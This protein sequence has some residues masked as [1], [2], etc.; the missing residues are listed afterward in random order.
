MT[1]TS[2]SSVADLVSAVPEVRL[3][4]QH[5]S[6]RPVPYNM[7]DVSFLIGSVPGCD[8]RVPGTNLPPV[9]CLLQRRPGNVVLRKLAPA[10]PILVNGA[11][12]ANAALKHGDRLTLGVVDVVVQIAAGTPEAGPAQTSMHIETARRQLQQQLQVFRE[13]VLQF[14][15]QKISWEQ[16]RQQLEQQLPPRTTKTAGGKDDV[17]A[18]SETALTKKAEELEQFRQ[19]LAAREA[20]LD[21]QRQELAAMR[22]EL[23]NIRKELYDKYQERRDKLAGIQEAVNKAARKVQERKQQV[24]G[25]LLQMNLRQQEAGRRERDLDDRAAEVSLQQQRLEEE[26]RLLGERHRESQQ[27]LTQRLADCQRHE[28]KLTDERRQLEQDQAQYQEDLVRLHRLQGTLE[29][30]DKKLQERA[31]ALDSRGNDLQAQEQKLEEQA[32]QLDEWHSR[33]CALAEQLDR[34]KQKQQDEAQGLAQKTTA[35][36]GQQAMLTNLRGRLEQMRD[37]LRK[38]EQQ[39]TEECAQQQEREK[40]LQAQHTELQQLRTT[41]ETEKAALEQERLQLTERGKTLENAVSQLRQAQTKLAEAE[42][43]LQQDAQ[44]LE[45][46]ITQEA[47]RVK[48]VETKEVQLDELQQRLEADRQALLERMQLLSQ[49]EQ[50]RE[51]LQEQ[52][53]RRSEELS[54]RQKALDEQTRQYQADLQTLRQQQQE[55]EQQQQQMTARVQGHIQEIEV[56]AEEMARQKEELTQREVQLESSREKLQTQGRSIAEKLKQLQTERA[57]LTQLA[58]ETTAATQQARSEY[59]AAR[60]EALDLQ[61][62]L[63][64]LELRAGTAFERLS[65][66]RE[67]LREYIGEVHTYANQCQEHL[68]GLRSGIQSEGERLHTREQA[69]RKQQ[70]EQRLALAGFRQQLIDWQGQMAEIKRLLAENEGRLELRQAEV[71]QKARLVTEESSRLAQQAVELEAEKRAVAHR[72]E[73]IDQHLE[74]MQQWYRHKLRELSGVADAV[75]IGSAGAAATSVAGEAVPGRD[76]LSL[77]GAVDP[78]DR[79]L[80][81]TLQTLGLIDT[82]VLTALL[83]EARRQRRSLRQVLLASG[84]VTLYQM[85]LIEAG[86]LDGLM[87][88]P[89]R[90]VDRLYAT[91]HEAVYRV[92]DPQRGQEAVLRHLSEAEMEDAV[93]PDEFRQRFTQAM[94][95]HPNIQATLTVLDLA[96]RPAALQEWLTGLVSLDWPQLAAVPGVWF[97]LVN[98]A[99]LALHTGHQAGL[100]HGHLRPNDFLLTSDGVVKLCGLSDPPWLVL[101]PVEEIQDSSAG[102]MAV[103]GRIVSRWAEHGEGRRGKAFPAGLKQI[104]ERLS[105]AS[106][107][108]GYPETGTLLQALDAV[109]AEVPANPEAWDRL[110]RHV[111][112]HAIG[113]P[114]LR[115]SA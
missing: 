21:R 40:D 53:R 91:A 31:A 3:E 20:D 41:L 83:I 90:V 56:R 44:A 37:E 14:E 8:L 113:G 63:P 6:A 26:R 95:T 96:G 27:Q 34:Q 4:V 80:G 54:A 30:Q 74:D 48:T 99:A 58:Q 84:T 98:Q 93:H 62:K 77:T 1:Q 33:L 66:A 69:L 112:E 81:T 89:V 79:E 28:Q 114:V 85:A 68:D 2:S 108:D 35:L 9:L 87:L 73:T 17:S 55:L 46:R 104:L 36:E 18:T 61:Q 105:N 82:D 71:T 109:S 64:D 13:Q 22:Q 59:E 111:R 100:V 47:E 10:Y 102:D 94:L 49:A 11:P 107:A 38:A 7:A 19:G 15:Q 43:R 57:Q 12:A 25:E 106:P 24:D 67:Q 88:G 52:L 75:H 115:Q 5:G 42:Q 16:Q 29:E 92:F 23:A 72:R 110:L 70:D 103:F 86:N 45:I 60:K 78:T 65:Y 76:I 51:T 39:L 50:A 97:R 101:P 32:V